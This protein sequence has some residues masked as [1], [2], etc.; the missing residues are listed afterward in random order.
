L[1]N[2]QLAIL[3]KVFGPEH[4][5]IAETL[6]VLADVMRAQGD[7]VEARQLVERAVAIREKA[8]GPED[9]DTA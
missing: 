5:A 4:P 3:E 2:A 1:A 7:V 9:P 8:F 6:N